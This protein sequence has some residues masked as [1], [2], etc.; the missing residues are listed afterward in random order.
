MSILSAKTVILGDP[1]K[2]ADFVL[3]AKFL[4]TVAPSSSSPKKSHHISS[5]KSGK[6]GKSNNYRGNRHRGHKSY[7]KN[8]LRYQPYSNS[9]TPNNPGQTFT[10][11]PNR[12]STG[13]ELRY[14]FDADYHTL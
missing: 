6:S 4:V 14:Y 7:D 8:N 10:P 2:K 1:V 9:Y 12:G 11:T 3:T 5:L 13:V